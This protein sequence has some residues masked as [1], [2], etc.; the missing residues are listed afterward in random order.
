M[1]IAISIVGY[2]LGFLMFSAG[3]CDHD[4]WFS[5]GGIFL[6]LLSTYL[7]KK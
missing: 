4:I 3:I 5:G 2:Y 6:L 7:L 1:N